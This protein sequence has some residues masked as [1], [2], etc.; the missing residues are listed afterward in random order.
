MKTNW[1]GIVRMKRQ[2][3]VGTKEMSFRGRGGGG[4]G[5]RGFGSFGHGG[6][7]GNRGGSNRSGGYDQGLPEQVT[8]KNFH[9][10]LT[11]VLEI[12][13]FTHTCEDDIVCHN[14]SGKIPYFNAAIFFENKEQVGKVDE[15]FGGIKD[16]GFTVKLQDGIKASS[17]K[18]AQKLYI[19]SG[20]LL[21][22][23][24]FL[25]N[26]ANK[27]GR[28]QKSGSGRGNRGH[29]SSDRSRFRGRGGSS[30]SRGGGG[31]RGGFRGSNR[32]SFGGGR[33][34]SGRGNGYRGSESGGS[35]RG[36]GRGNDLRNKR[37][38]GGHSETIQNKRMKF[39]N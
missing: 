2:G 15:I 8:G 1:A 25:P 6:R 14:T 34:W 35:F 18:E 36:R 10:S 30:F 21:P 33:D 17:F 39:D 11:F 23:E 29:S 27:R 12:G 5:S 28:E 9:H 4:G 3:G 26:G 37:S 13:Y 22:I 38:F 20:R 7:R 19:D 16:N 31:D 32:G 24:R